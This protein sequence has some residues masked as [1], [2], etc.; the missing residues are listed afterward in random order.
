MTGGYPPDLL[1]TSGGEVWALS[2]DGSKILFTSDMNIFPDYHEEGP[3]T[4][5]PPTNMSTYLREGDSLRWLTPAPSLDF[6][7]REMKT[8]SE[9]SCG[10][11]RMRIANTYSHFSKGHPE[12]EAKTACQESRSRIGR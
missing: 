6:S 8:P 7:V 9:V 5:S 1:G 2:E 11:V 3:T 10:S 4:G 12:G